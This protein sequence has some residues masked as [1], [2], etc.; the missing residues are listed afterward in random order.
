[1]LLAQGAGELPRGRKNG[2][3]GVQGECPISNRL[4]SAELIEKLNLTNID[5]FKY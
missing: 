2:L 5:P 1:M 3:R 4:D